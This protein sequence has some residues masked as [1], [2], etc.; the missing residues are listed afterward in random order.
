[1]FELTRF[2]HSFQLVSSKRY[3]VYNLHKNIMPKNVFKLRNVKIGKKSFS[4]FIYNFFIHF[5]YVFLKLLLLSDFI[6]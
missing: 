5:R 3:F 1:M 6:L 2:Q 4:L